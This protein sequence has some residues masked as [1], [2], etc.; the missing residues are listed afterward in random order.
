MA[1][2]DVPKTS[3]QVE[4]LAAGGA[5]WVSVGAVGMASTEEDGR[6]KLDDMRTRGLGIRF[7]LIEIS[8]RVIE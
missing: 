5:S 7:R 3:Y 2:N 1:D 8:R 6:R 4:I